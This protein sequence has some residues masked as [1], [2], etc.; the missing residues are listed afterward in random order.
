[1]APYII[2]VCIKYH[3]IHNIYFV[4]L[5]AIGSNSLNRFQLGFLRVLKLYMAKKNLRKKKKKKRV[6]MKRYDGE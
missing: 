3:V 6:K 5:N 2:S 1:M 4:S